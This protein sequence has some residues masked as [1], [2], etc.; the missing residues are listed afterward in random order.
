MMRR[1]GWAYMSAATTQKALRVLIVELLAAVE[2]D[3]VLE[4]EGENVG[5]WARVEKS[6][7]VLVGVGDRAY[8]VARVASR[9]G[10]AARLLVP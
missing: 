8:I 7:L 1:R 3:D 10:R 4:D 6:G 2:E 9:G 5:L